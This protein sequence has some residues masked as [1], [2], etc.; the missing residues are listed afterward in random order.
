M[1]GPSSSNSS[2]ISFIHSNGNLAFLFAKVQ[3]F[4]HVII[5]AYMTIGFHLWNVSLSQEEKE[6]FF[7]AINIVCNW[8]YRWGGISLTGRLNSHISEF[9]F[10]GSILFLK[11][12]LF[13]KICLKKTGIIQYAAWCPE[14][15]FTLHFV[16]SL[17]TTFFILK[18]LFLEANVLHN[19]SYWKLLSPQSSFVFLSFV[20]ADRKTRTFFGTSSLSFTL[21]KKGGGSSFQYFCF[22][23]DEVRAW[24]RS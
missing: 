14:V 5:F 3:N 17:L 22:S 20:N 13:C 19:N 8:E 21:V 10:F 4:K 2:K 11:A 15:A 6:S 9:T 23:N 16:H 12:L 24:C 7:I 18:S 1:F